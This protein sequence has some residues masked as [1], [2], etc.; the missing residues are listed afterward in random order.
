VSEIGGCDTPT[1]I[2]AVAALAGAVAVT[3]NRVHVV[4]GA[5]LW[6]GPVGVPMTELDELK[7]MIYGVT[8]DGVP[9]FLTENDPA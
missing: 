1:Q 6:L 5:T 2:E 7:K 9:D 3:V 8:V 4:D